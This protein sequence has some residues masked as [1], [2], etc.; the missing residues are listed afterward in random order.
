M[1]G[2]LAGGFVSGFIGSAGDMNGAVIGMITAGAFGGLQGFAKGA[3]WA[4]D[5]GKALVKTVAHGIVGGMRSAL[6]GGDFRS[7]FLGSAFT[8]GVSA[9]NLFHG[10]GTD[11][12]NWKVRAKRVFAS[13]IVGGTGARVGGGKFANGAA[14]AAMGYLFGSLLESA[15]ETGGGGIPESG[16]ARDENGNI[17][18]S[19]E[20]SGTFSDTELAVTDPFHSE[21]SPGRYH[22]GLDLAP[23]P[24]GTVANALSVTEGTVVRIGARGFGDNAVVIRTP[25]GNQAIYGRLASATLRYGDTVSVG[26]TIGVIG[27]AGCGSCGVHLHFEMRA[28]PRPYLGPRLGVR[29]P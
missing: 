13:A 19:D 10:L 1:L 20:I 6:S 11:P 26:S 4:K 9:T 8:M 17:I 14:T 18:Y 2:N 16:F 24:R 15:S 23:R 3:T 29:Y 21:R 7:G 12:T 28:S 25:G 5:F 27:N 22:A